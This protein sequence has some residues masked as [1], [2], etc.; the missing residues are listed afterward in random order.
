MAIAQAQGYSYTFGQFVRWCT[1]QRDCPL[2]GSVAQATQQVLRLIA[3]ASVRPLASAQP[4]GQRADGDVVRSAIAASMQ[5]TSWWPDLKLALAW[6]L[7]SGVGSFL[8]ALAGGDSGASDSNEADVETA[9]N[10]IDQALPRSVAAYQ[11]AAARAA[12]VSPLFRSEFVWG[13]LSC[14][15]WPVPGRQVLS[16]PAS[17]TA[18]VPPVLVLGEVHDR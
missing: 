4:G 6:A 14:A 16:G 10:C 15:Y 2:R 11:A 7:N 17:G 9:V 13:W 18:A 12:K 3:R 8:V 1:V 5:L